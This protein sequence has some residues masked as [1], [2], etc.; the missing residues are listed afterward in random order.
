MFNLDGGHVGR[1]GEN[2]TRRLVAA[3]SP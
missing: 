1:K 3:Q 2:A